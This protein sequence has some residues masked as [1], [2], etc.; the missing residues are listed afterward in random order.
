[1]D[2]SGRLFVAWTE[3][4]ATDLGAVFLASTDLQGKWDVHI[5]ELRAGEGQ[6]YAGD[7]QM[8]VVSSDEIVLV[9]DEMGPGDGRLHAVHAHPCA[10]GEKP[11]ALPPAK[12]AADFW[13]KTVDEAVTMIL[14]GMDEESKAKIRATA[15]DDLI[16]YH[17]G[18]GTGIRNSFGL[19]GGNTALRESCGSATIHPDECSMIIIRAVWKRLQSE[20]APK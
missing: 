19:W 20:P 18:W 1:V 7:I 3:R 14:E 8:H 11:K 5:E 12:K 4:R 16:M 9:W 15:E 6:S 2:E 13:P 10:E 17:H